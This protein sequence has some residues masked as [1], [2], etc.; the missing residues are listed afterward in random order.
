[1]INVDQELT[2]VFLIEAI[3]RLT[4]VDSQWAIEG[5]EIYD[6]LVWLD[7]RYPKPE[8]SAVAAEQSSLQ[9]EWEN[10]R[11]QRKRVREY[12]DLKVL[13]D[14]LYWQSKGDSTKMAEYIAACESVKVKYPK[15]S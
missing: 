3:K 4:P 1:M 7:T 12:P 2:P 6:N 9:T 11:Y 8:R 15:Q 5:E 14:A 10:T 13:A